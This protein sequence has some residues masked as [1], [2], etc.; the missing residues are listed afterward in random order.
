MCN[1]AGAIEQEGQLEKL[2]LDLLD[3]EQRNQREILKVRQSTR[4]YPPPHP[5]VSKRRQ[6]EPFPSTSV[7]KTRES[8]RSEER[9]V[10]HN[11]A[12]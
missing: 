7:T 4:P 10:A 9:E 1:V 11:G 8:L 5:H 12:T 6:G 2:Q 3:L